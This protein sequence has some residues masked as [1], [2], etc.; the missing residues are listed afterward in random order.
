MQRAWAAVIGVVGAAAAVAASCNDA[1]GSNSA[2]ITACRAY[3][4]KVIGAGCAEPIY[5]SAGTC[6]AYECSS[7]DSATERCQ[8]ASK[9]Y[10]DCATKRSD[11]C[12]NTG[13]ARELDAAIYCGGGGRAGTGGRGGAGGRGAASGQGGLAGVGGGGGTGGTGGAAGGWIPTALGPRL[14]A[15]LDATQETG[16]AHG[17]EMGQWTDR[18]GA[19]N[20]ALQPLMSYR[21]VYSTQGINGLPTVTFRGT[22]YFVLRTRSRCASA[23]VTSRSWWWRAVRL[24]RS[25]T[26]RC[27]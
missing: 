24:P 6:K 5:A 16:L 17:A 7:L 9:A 14:V 26:P 18:S 2:A 15:W 13:C 10:Y 19:N 20:H 21:P 23:R 1:G 8:N 12:A 11:Q 25:P 27:F 4:D 22:N 3:C